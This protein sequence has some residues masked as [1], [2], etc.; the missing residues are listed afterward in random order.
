MEPIL[1]IAASLTS[2]MQTA[3]LTFQHIGSML[4]FFDRPPGLLRYDS[5]FQRAKRIRDHAVSTL[6]GVHDTR[7]IAL[8]LDELD[9][10]E[11][12]MPD[13]SLWDNFEP[14]AKWVDIHLSGAE[15]RQIVLE[16][17]LSTLI[18]N[19]LLLSSARAL[20]TLEK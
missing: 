14:V 17:S 19:P 9:A 8:I 15:R 7:K 1:S 13:K 16:Q 18:N 11:K 4:G 20:V 10:I 12:H 6:R 5:L 3:K 2:A